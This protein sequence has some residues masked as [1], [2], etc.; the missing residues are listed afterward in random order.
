MLQEKILITILFL[1]TVFF[2]HAQLSK[3]NTHY[4][5][6]KNNTIGQ[7][8][9]IK[10]D[11]EYRNWDKSMMITTC[12]ANDM[13]TAF[14]NGHENSVLDL[15]ALYFTAD[16]DNLFTTNTTDEQ[17]REG[18]NTLSDSGCVLD[19]PSVDDNGNTNYTTASHISINNGIS[20][21]MQEGFQPSRLRRQTINGNEPSY[22]TL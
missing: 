14:K 11:G 2:N 13:A 6:N 18:D 21:K 17:S 12:G 7:Q 3:T 16:N 15:Y 22:C 19:I 10:I 5:T 1:V 9:S 20:Y 8:A 4:S